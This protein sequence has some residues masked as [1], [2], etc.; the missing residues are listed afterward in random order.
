MKLLKWLILLLG[1]LVLISCSEKKDNSS[2]V[3]FTSLY[4]NLFSQNCASCHVEGQQAYDID[5]VT[6]DFST[7]T[8]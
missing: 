8:K 5:G 7:Q 1:S 6:L 2:E 3:T 4:T